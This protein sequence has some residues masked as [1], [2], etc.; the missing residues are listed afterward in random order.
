MQPARSPPILILYTSMVFRALQRLNIRYFMLGFLLAVLFAGAAGTNQPRPLTSAAV[1]VTLY[2]AGDLLWTKVR[3]GVLYLPLSSVLSGLI[4]SIVLD[5]TSPWWV[6]A[7]FPLLAVA[8]KHLL[9]VQNKHVFNP[10]A[11]SLVLLSFLHP[12]AISWWAV[13]WW[14]PAWKIIG[15][16]AGV[17]ILTRIRRWNVTLPFLA[18]YVA[19]LALSLVRGGSSLDALPPIIFDGTLIF[20]ASVML[21]EPVTTTYRPASLQVAYGA[22]V[23]LLAVLLPFLRVPLPDG[24][25]PPL[26]LGNFLASLASMRRTRPQRA[27]L[28]NA[29]AV[30]SPQP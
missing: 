21:V 3:G 27:P 30:S 11:L 18:V 28:P 23:G 20:F 22:V 19:G 9:R 25:L 1:M 15:M 24:F 29:P 17:V 2:V 12:P 10:A 14:G 8:G 5:P 26:L 4:G 13:A 16:L 7:A 6:V